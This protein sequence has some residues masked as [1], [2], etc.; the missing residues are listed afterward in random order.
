MTPPRQSLPHPL[1]PSPSVPASR[2]GPCACPAGRGLPVGQRPWSPCAPALQAAAVRPGVDE[3]CK[4]LVKVSATS[5][6]LVGL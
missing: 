6:L 2:A 4:V 5:C 3:T 1:R